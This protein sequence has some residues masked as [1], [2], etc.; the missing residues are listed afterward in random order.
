M[1][2]LLAPLNQSLS[3]TWTWKLNL[4][5]GSALQAILIPWTACICQVLAT[6]FGL[7][8]DGKRIPEASENL[9]FVRLGKF[10]EIIQV[11]LK[12][13]W[14]PSDVISIAKCTDLMRKHAKPREYLTL[15]NKKLCA[16]TRGK[17]RRL[18]RVPYWYIINYLSG[19]LW[20][21]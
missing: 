6:G 21:R 8:G 11:Y 19:Y 13:I 10:L 14:Y 20:G 4:E 15:H 1:F 5:I 2:P 16:F 9:Q 3:A 18:S 17:V 7:A 12:Y